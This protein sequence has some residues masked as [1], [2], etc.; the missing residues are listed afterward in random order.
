M[1]MKDFEFKCELNREEYRSIKTMG[2]QDMER[3]ISGI[4]NE[5]YVIGFREGQAEHSG[6]QNTD[7]VARYDKE[8]RQL[9][10]LHKEIKQI[11]ERMAIICDQEESSVAAVVQA[12]GK[13]WPYLTKSMAIISVDPEC[14]EERKRALV[15][16]RD[17]LNER[18]KYCSELETR[19]LMFI[20][21]IEESEPRRIAEYRYLEGMKWE[22]IGK[23]MNADRTTPQK[24]LKRELIKWLRREKMPGEET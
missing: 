12:S 24:Q 9:R 15:I 7:E 14:I 2:R 1:L 11:E 3:Y 17:L 5:A 19:I 6:Q 23:L 13:T 8:F 20:S 10:S 4:Y 22:D 21:G 16:Q 18:L